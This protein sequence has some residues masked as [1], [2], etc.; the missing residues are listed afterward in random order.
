MPLTFTQQDFLGSILVLDLLNE[1]NS[2][3]STD[4]TWRVELTRST[5][6]Q[7]IF[8]IALPLDQ[9]TIHK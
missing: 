9:F 4:G 7:M 3:N 5:D 2:A 8:F 1:M 6:G